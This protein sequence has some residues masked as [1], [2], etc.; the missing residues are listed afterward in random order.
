MDLKQYIILSK[1]DIAKK[2]MN[3]QSSNKIDWHIKEDDDKQLYF[4]F[5]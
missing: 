3:Y 5:S 2:V 4:K 1:K